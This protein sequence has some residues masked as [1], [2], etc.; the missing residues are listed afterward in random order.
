MSRDASALHLGAAD[1]G[2]VAHDMSGVDGAEREATEAQAQVVDAVEATSGSQEVESREQKTLPSSNLVDRPPRDPSHDAV[3]TGN[4]TVVTV[5]APDSVP[6]QVAAANGHIEPDNGKQYILIE[7]VC[8]HSTTASLLP[9]RENKLIGSAQSSPPQHPS[10]PSRLYPVIPSR[11]QPL[12]Q[13]LGGQQT[14]SL[15]PQILPNNNLIPHRLP[16]P[17]RSPTPRRDHRAWMRA[18]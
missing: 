15:P 5:L 9:E 16:L 3:A 1:R 4:H 7:H 12:V 6:N 2:D 14:S 10:H 11:L 17:L 8:T 18:K 13:I